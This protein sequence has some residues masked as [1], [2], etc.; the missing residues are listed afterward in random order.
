MST[1]CRQV[2]RLKLQGIVGIGVS[3]KLAKTMVILG[4]VDDKN[5]Y[6]FDGSKG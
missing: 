6:V 3:K 4:V 2:E 5:I 1:A